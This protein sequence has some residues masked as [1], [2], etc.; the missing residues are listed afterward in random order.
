[1]DECRN[2][3]HWEGLHHYKTMQCPKGGEA[4]VGQ[5]QEYLETV[6]SPKT[7]GLE[8]EVAEL[9]IRVKSL[10]EKVEVLKNTLTDFME[11]SS[12]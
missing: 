7:E 8:N 1:M 11:L 9:R 10:E 5:R 6:F 12:Y 3:G 2:C 4:P